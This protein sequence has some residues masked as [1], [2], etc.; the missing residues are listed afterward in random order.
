MQ[1]LIENTSASREPRSALM[2]IL[3]VSLSL[4]KKGERAGTTTGFESTSRQDLSST[5]PN[6]VRATRMYSQSEIAFT[7]DA[8]P[9]NSETQIQPD[10]EIARAISNELH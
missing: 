6:A 8:A 9:K 7:P 10:A 3:A 4:Y 2:C 5:P 1:S